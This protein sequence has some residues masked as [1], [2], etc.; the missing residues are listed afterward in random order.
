MSKMDDVNRIGQKQAKRIYEEKRL[1][2]WKSFV[3]CLM[4]V[5]IVMGISGLTLTNILGDRMAQLE[6]E[7][8]TQDDTIEEY[9]QAMVLKREFV[10]NLSEE[11]MNLTLRVVELEEKNAYY[12]ELADGYI[13]GYRSL[14]EF[15]D[16]L[17]GQELEFINIIKK[18]A[19][20]HE[21][22]VN[23]YNCMDFSKEDVRQLR[24]YGYAASKLRVKVDCDSGLFNKTICEKYKGRHMISVVCIP[25]EGTPP[26]NASGGGHIIPVWQYDDYNIKSWML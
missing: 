7:I 25:L 18:V 8:R 4:L 10:S 26:I 22:V 6:K 16:P 5:I 9:E 1:L 19:S 12:K 11:A 20:E 23:E 17:W 13:K 15:A 14:K 24:D 2:K 21:Y 3:A